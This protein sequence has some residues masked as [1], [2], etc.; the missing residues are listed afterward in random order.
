MKRWAIG[1]AMLSFGL[2]ASAQD[3][4]APVPAPAA[5]A[6]PAAAAVGR[7]VAAPD[8]GLPSL[9]PDVV[10]DAQAMSALRR[11][12]ALAAARAESLTNQVRA[13]ELQLQLGGSGGLSEIPEL[14]GLY[15]TPQ[16]T[17][18]EFLVGQSVLTASVGDWV[19]AEWR[20]SRVME[21]GVEVERGDGKARRTVLFGRRSIP[22]SAVAAPRPAVG[23]PV[24][25]AAPVPAQAFRAGQ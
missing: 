24:P 10:R 18:A 16:R 20:L 8:D 12:A 2:I 13:Q 1:M 21:N 14:I 23:V 11:E 6:V 15:A 4:A 17:W 7:A 5:S 25:A 9:G 19:T 3:G 22:G